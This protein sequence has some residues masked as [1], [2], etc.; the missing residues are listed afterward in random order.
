MHI[1]T[2]KN[3]KKQNYRIYPLYFSNLFITMAS[4]S[5]CKLSTEFR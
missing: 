1:N 2:E 3:T 4:T 5:Y